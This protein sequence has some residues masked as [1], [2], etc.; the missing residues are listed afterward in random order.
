MNTLILSQLDS[1]QGPL[2]L[3]IDA[4][5]RVHALDFTE[6]LSPARRRM[7]FGAAQGGLRAGPAP[8]S[9]SDALARYFDG[10]WAALDALPVRTQGDALQEQ[11]WAAL[12]RIPA[13]RTVSYGQLARSL[14]LQDPRAAIDVGAANAANPIALIIPCHRVVAATAA[15]AATPGAWCA[16]AGCWRTN[17]LWRR[18]R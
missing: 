6:G 5:G 12:R 17:T 8:A 18:R 3:V 16:N 2:R 9:V 15:C 10:D 1:P 13:G 4:Q 7:G 11:V 14:G